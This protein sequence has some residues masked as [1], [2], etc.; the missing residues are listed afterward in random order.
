MDSIT[1]NTA[2][3]IAFSQPVMA[4]HGTLQDRPLPLGVSTFVETPTAQLQAEGILLEK[5]HFGI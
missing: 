3:G 2:T 4:S 5:K 1:F